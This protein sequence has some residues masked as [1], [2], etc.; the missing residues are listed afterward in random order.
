M[1]LIVCIDLNK[2]MLFNNRRQSR[3]RKIV[4]NIRDLIDENK[5]WITEFSKD[6][7]ENTKYNLFEINNTE[8]IKEEDYVFIENYSPKILEDKLN[9][10]ILFNWNR[11][12]S[13]D[14][15]FDILLENWKLE[16]EI[17]FEGFSHEKI[18]RKIYKRKGE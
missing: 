1:K 11:N 10:I 12:Y 7:F 14:L 9:E 15:F 8:D 18:G 6:M 16:S 17:E 4:E 2:G 5:L 13:A 3:D